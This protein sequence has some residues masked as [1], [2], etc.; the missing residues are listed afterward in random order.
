MESKTRFNKLLANIF[1]AA[2][3]RVVNLLVTMAI[4]PLTINALGAKDYAVLAMAISLSVF[5]TY[6]DFGMGLAV[7][8][9]VARIES[10]SNIRK[11]LRAVSTVWYLLSLIGFCGVVLC[12]VVY[13]VLNLTLAP[14]GFDTW[15]PILIGVCSVFIGLPTGL[16]QRILFAKQKN[17]EANI[18][19]TI[20]RVLSLVCVYV[21]IKSGHTSLS[22]LIFCVLGSPVIV[23]WVS[24]IVC[25][26][27]RREISPS[28]RYFSTKY[29]RVLLVNGFRFFVMQMVP[30][31]EGG[32]DSIIVG[33]VVGLEYVAAMDV[34]TKIFSYI[35]ALVSLGAFPLW[36]AIANAKNSGDIAWV[37]KICQKAF[38]VTLLLSSAVAFV[39]SIFGH[40][41]VEKWTGL[42]LHLDWIVLLGIALFSVLAAVGMIL[43][44]ILNGLS[45]IKQQVN[46][47]CVYVIFLFAGKLLLSMAFGL[48]GVVWSAIIAYLVRLCLS[49]KLYQMA[50]K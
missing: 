7:V 11:S 20:G 46:L 44:I 21:A 29:I 25:F 13:G 3:S 2:A 28:W 19:L 31:F 18:W 37:K 40:L 4:V 47:L 9:L 41:L 43:S 15:T 30:Y 10:V 24:V 17:I 14:L 48:P 12:G 35:P 1:G 38:V 26:G 22:V 36:P 8:N 42:S 39:L 32:I 6:A 33:S 27:V 34:Y 23:G 5:V 45:V 49:R 50:F 16:V